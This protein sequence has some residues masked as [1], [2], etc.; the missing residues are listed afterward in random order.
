MPLDKN[1]L[2]VF[3]QIIG[4]SEHRILVCLEGSP[5][6]VSIEHVQSFPVVHKP[7]G[8]GV[9]VWRSPCPVATKT[10]LLFVRSPANHPVLTNW[11][12]PPHSLVSW[13]LLCLV[14]ALHMWSFM[15]HMGSQSRGVQEPKYGQKARSM[16]GGNPGGPP[17]SMWGGV[18]Y[19]LDACGPSCEYRDALKMLEGLECS[20]VESLTARWGKK[21]HQV[22]ATEGWPLLRI[23]GMATEV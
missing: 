14:F 9:T 16:C 12:F 4:Y 20:L 19:F 6:T 5:L 3:A 2:E 18:A 10:V 1:N 17:S 8:Q 15:K 11:T 22:A 13:L 21:V 23:G 7:W